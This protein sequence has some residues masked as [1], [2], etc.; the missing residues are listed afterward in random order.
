[1]VLNHHVLYQSSVPDRAKDEGL[2]AGAQPG[3]L[4]IATALDIEDAIIG[5]AVFIIADQGQSGHAAQSQKAD[6][7]H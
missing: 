1:M 4:C 2:I 5:P 3:G 7:G 6:V